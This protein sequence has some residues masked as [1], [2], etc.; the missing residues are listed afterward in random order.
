MP[1]PEQR[2]DQL[3]PVISEQLAR[4]DEIAAK[5]ER[6]SAQV[7][8]LTVVVTQALSAQSDNISFLLIRTQ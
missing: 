8:Q 7:R 2:L 6:V 4:Q 3:E 5:V 1:S